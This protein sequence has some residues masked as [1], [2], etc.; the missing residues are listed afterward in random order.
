MRHTSPFSTIFF[1]EFSIVPRGIVIALIAR[2]I[3]IMKFL[4]SD[5]DRPFILFSFSKT[6]SALGIFLCQRGFANIYETDTK[7]FDHTFGV[8]IGKMSAKTSAS[9]V[10]TLGLYKIVIV[11]PFYFKLCSIIIV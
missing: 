8:E 10:H 2:V 3:V 7:K 11:I 9:Y 6:T 4:Y 1:N 5:Y